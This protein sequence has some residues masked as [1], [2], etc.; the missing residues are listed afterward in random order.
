VLFVLF[1]VVPAIYGLYLS[2]TSETLTG[3][4]SNLIGFA[5]YAEALQNPDMWRSLGNTL[6][7]TLL[8]TIPLV[9]LSLA[10]ALLAAIIIPPQ[11]LIVHLFRQML[12]FDLVDAY[13]GIILPQAFAPAMVLILKRFFDQ[14]RVE[15]EDAAR[16]DGANRLRVFW[17]V[18]LPLSRPILAAVAIF[19]FIG[20]WNLWRFRWSWCSCSSSGRSSRASRPRVSAGS[21]ER[22]SGSAGWES[23]HDPLK[24][25]SLSARLPRSALCGEAYRAEAT[26]ARVWCCEKRCTARTVANINCPSGDPKRR[27][28][29]VSHESARRAVP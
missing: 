22:L 19:V 5:N 12:A 11:L 23:C 10:F 28:I 20:A 16:V 6:L 7:F 4:N 27:G 13:W 1:L 25:P 18:V 21:N 24:T 29:C 15:L 17:S 9:L 14:I 26:V 2:F 3:A 8:S